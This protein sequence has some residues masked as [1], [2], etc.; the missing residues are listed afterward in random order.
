LRIVAGNDPLA[1]CDSDSGCNSGLGT[2]NIRMAEASDL[3][4][5]V[6]CEDLAFNLRPRT[7]PDK[8]V[9]PHG[10]LAAQIGRG[11]I[12]VIG[13]KSQFLGYISFSRKHD[14]L[15]VAAIAVL[16][17][18][19]RAGV[20]SRL[21][22]YAGATACRLGLGTVHLFTDGRNAGNVKFYKQRGYV[23]TGRCE[24]GEFLRVYLSKVI[25][26]ANNQ[27]TLTAA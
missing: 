4:A 5:V 18:Y 13:A 22:L 10:E 7:T 16:P 25:L 9:S 6:A 23:E 14:H 3:A 8:N 19:H 21:L 12:H 26:P 24:E 1:T 15:F 20:G 2:T 17:K 27:D 11:D